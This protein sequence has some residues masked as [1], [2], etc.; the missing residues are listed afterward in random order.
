[1][2]S[3]RILFQGIGRQ[4]AG[5]PAGQF[6]HRMVGGCRI[7]R[8]L[9]RPR[10]TLCFSR[11]TLQP[12]SSNIGRGDLNGSEICLGRDR[13]LGCCW[14]SPP[15]RYIDLAPRPGRETGKSNA[16]AAALRVWERLK[17][18]RLLPGNL[19]KKHN[20]DM[21]SFPVELLGW[22]E[23]DTPMKPTS[24]LDPNFLFDAAPSFCVRFERW[25]L[26]PA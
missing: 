19:E 8:H 14:L 10:T 7:R 23:V 11:R 26:Q 1:M 22:V 24:P 18:L 17:P 4:P 6:R 25:W 15:V 21:R 3:G 20:N 16:S 5:F 12:G 2:P 9:R 13:D